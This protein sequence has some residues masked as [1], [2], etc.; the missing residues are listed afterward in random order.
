MQCSN[1]IL[2]TH[3]TGPIIGIIICWIH[4]QFYRPC[5]TN[6]LICITIVWGF[7]YVLHV[8][9]A[10][11]LS[12]YGQ[13]HNLQS[14][15]TLCLFSLVYCNWRM[16]RSC[17]GHTDTVTRLPFGG[18]MSIAKLLFLGRFAVVPDLWD[19]STIWLNGWLTHTVSLTTSTQC[20]QF[21]P[22]YGKPLLFHYNTHIRD[23]VTPCFCIYCGSFLA[24]DSMLAGPFVHIDMTNWP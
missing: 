8:L 20:K 17:Q 10:Y 2:C 12:K 22:S 16:I 13:T 18:F 5:H 3:P 9:Y 24:T 19:T 23:M 11:T 1:C 14:I 21:Q 7:P 6:W 15:L 4:A